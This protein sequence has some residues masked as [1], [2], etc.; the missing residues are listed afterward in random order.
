MLACRRIKERRREGASRWR[1][2]TLFF[3]ERCRKRWGVC[4]CAHN[5]VSVDN[6]PSDA[7]G[8]DHES[9][10]KHS[11]RQKWRRK[12]RRHLCSFEV[13]CLSEQPSQNDECGREI[14]MMIIIIIM[15]RRRML[16]SVCPHKGLNWRTSPS[17][18]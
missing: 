9:A 3:H 11:D 8:A 6:T 14:M 13:N 7:E 1:R 12:E 18:I 4:E 10:M 17:S 2:S 16:W 5:G 15:R